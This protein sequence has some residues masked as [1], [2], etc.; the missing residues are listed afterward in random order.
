VT[1]C[2]EHDDGDGDGYGVQ[3]TLEE[4]ARAILCRATD[5]LLDD[6]GTPDQETRARRA[7]AL[8]GDATDLLKRFLARFDTEMTP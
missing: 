8:V 4:T 5:A 3:P 2:P 6:E 1:I 7:L